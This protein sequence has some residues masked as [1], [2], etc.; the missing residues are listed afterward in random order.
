M[1]L[2]RH[3]GSEHRARSEEG[4]ENLE[5]RW[6]E[7]IFLKVEIDAAPLCSCTL[8]GKHTAEVARPT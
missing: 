1:T 4:T 3:L 6:S 5:R 8:G 7:Y 2:K